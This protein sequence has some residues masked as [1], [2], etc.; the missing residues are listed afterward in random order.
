MNNNKYDEIK[1]MIAKIQEE[2]ALIDSYLPESEINSAIDWDLNLV[3]IR[4]DSLK[5]AFEVFVRKGRKVPD[6]FI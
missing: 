5:T 1:K 3:R 4:A 2:L 6:Y